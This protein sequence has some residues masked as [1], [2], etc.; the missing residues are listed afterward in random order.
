MLRSTDRAGVL[1]ATELAVLLVPLD[2]I[3]HAQRLVHVVDGALRAAS[4]EPHIGW[5]MRLEGHGLF[6]ASARADAERLRADVARLRL[7]A[8][9]PPLGPPPF[10]P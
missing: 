7:A 6:H 9:E 10:A 8:G 1:C 3:H 4:L 2:T 5:A